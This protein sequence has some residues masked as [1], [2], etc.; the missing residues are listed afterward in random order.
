MTTKT[1][2]EKTAAAIREKLTR[3]IIPIL[4]WWTEF[5]GITQ[6]YQ[7]NIGVL[8]EIPGKAPGGGDRAMMVNAEHPYKMISIL[9]AS[10]IVSPLNDQELEKCLVHEL[11]H[12]IL[13]PMTE[14]VMGTLDGPV[15]EGIH[16]QEEMVC[17]TLAQYF[18]RLKYG[19]EYS[20]ITIHRN[21]ESC[22]DCNAVIKGD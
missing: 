1:K 20:P 12:I 14:L 21:I 2:K 9:V 16:N 22:E 3:R 6:T 15:L 17:D 5:L 10:D 19:K 4:N 11:A 7:V 8:E 18:M 13:L